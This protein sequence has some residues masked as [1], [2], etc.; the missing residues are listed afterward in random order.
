MLGSV[1]VYDEPFWL[2]LYWHFVEGLAGVFTSR[3][4]RVP[5]PNW[6]KR[7]WRYCE[8]G[9]T[10]TLR[11]YYGTIGD[12]LFIHIHNPL[13][14]LHW[15]WHQKYEITIDLGYERLDTLFRKQEPEFFQDM[16]QHAEWRKEE[17]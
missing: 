11:E 5:L 4:F 2:W 3:A 7:E 1:H 14:Q 15:K 16:D 13:F 10:Y 17:K 12:L 6:P 8:P 9:E